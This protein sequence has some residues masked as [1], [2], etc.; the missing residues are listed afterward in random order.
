MIE[1]GQC[2]C[3]AK[4]LQRVLGEVDRTEDILNGTGTLP[5]RMPARVKDGLVLT[6][7]SQPEPNR[8]SNPHP[9]GFP[10]LTARDKP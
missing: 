4:G 5:S 2:P 10:A 1:Q 7:V 6:N 9:N 8:D 3:V